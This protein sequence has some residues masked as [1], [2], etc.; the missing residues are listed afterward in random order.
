MMSTTGKYLLSIGF[1]VAGVVGF[2]A[3][4]SLKRAPASAERE[5][6]PP[7]V[8]TRPVQERNEGFWLEVD[9]EVSPYREVTISAEVAGK[10][11]MKASQCFAGQY[12][13]KGT[14]LLQI[15][16][17]DYDLEVQRLEELTKQAKNSVEELDVEYQNTQALIKL[18][19][20]ELDLQRSEL[21]RITAL[22]RQNVAT[23]SDLDAARRIELASR[24]NM[25]AQQNQKS[26][27][28]KRRGGVVSEMRRIEAELRKARLDRERTEIRAPIDGI[29]T[30]DLVE[31]G[32]FVER[33]T[34]LVKLED[35][36]RVEVHFDLQYSQLQWLWQYMDKG[37]KP[38]D[39]TAGSS[40]ELPRLPVTVVL[41]VEDKEFQWRGHLARYDGAGVNTVT[42][43]VP[44]VAVVDE[45]APDRKS[46]RLNSSH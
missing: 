12:A 41:T 1:L 38:G 37:Q 7:A 18:A 2:I 15:N 20:E 21:E 8:K 24:N 27:L 10:I 4:S 36:S 17:L 19:R 28:E 34:P 39:V 5:I 9:G 29:V 11:E 31:A 46:T 32:A 45:R 26:L 16:T 6:Q 13:K 3:L 25:Q 14:F 42:R 22:Y 40:Y 44:C 33:G 35:T 30:E 43:T 23:D